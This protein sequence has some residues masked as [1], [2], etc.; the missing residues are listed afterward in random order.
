MTRETL[1][2]TMARHGFT[3]E[4]TGGGCTAW[5]VYLSDGSYI[6][7]T[8]SDAPTAPE[9]WRGKVSVSVYRDLDAELASAC[10]DF[11]SVRAAL[12]SFLPWVEIVGKVPAPW[13]AE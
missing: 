10:F 5:A 6:H 4:S 2:A 13:S 11:G 12:A 1:A 9:A 7:L 8:E 3:L